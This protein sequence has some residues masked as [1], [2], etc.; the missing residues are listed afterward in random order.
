MQCVV[1][2]GSKLV[3]FLIDQDIEDPGLFCEVWTDIL[4][5][6]ETEFYDSQMQSRKVFEM[7][8]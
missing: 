8:R 5:R 7:P 1:S 2:N 6:P 3:L 4:C